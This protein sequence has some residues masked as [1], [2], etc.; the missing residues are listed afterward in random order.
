MSRY[1]SPLRYPGG[2]ARMA[3]AVRAWINSQPD[4]PACLV[5]P[6]AG[7]AGVSLALLADDTIA[8]AHL[9]DL[10]PGLVAF[11]RTIT[12]SQ[13]ARAMCDLIEDTPVT[14]D[15]WHHCREAYTA[16][17][18]DD[19]TL[20]FATFFLNRTNRSGILGARPIGGLAQTGR[21]K[22]DARYNRPALIARIQAVATMGERITVSLA[23]A[24]DTIRATTSG[25]AL[26]VDPPYTGT[27]TGRLY[28]R[29][30]GVDGHARLAHT[31]SRARV[32]WLLTYDASPRIARLYE[33]I[34]QVRPMRW[35][36]TAHH[37]HIDTELIITCQEAA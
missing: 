24:T 13:G 3:G 26:F 18:G 4:T 7:G 31:L 17:A 1:L 30:L 37:P 35:A 8:T 33:S 25:Q 11:W 32:P 15:Q 36:H 6:F 27:G 29:D 12:T 5:E 10:N 34:G 23:D 14:I 16:G 21:W 28:D 20:G 2:K 19:L 9:G 22:I